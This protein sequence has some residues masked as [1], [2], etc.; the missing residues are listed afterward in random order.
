QLREQ[1]T[2]PQDI[3]SLLLIVGGDVVGRAL[4]QLSGGPITPVTFSFGWVG[5]GISSL[6][7]AAAGDNRLMPSSTDCSCL[8][9]NAKTGYARSNASWVLGRMMRDYEYWMHRQT[10]TVLDHVKEE[11]L[12]KE[13]APEASPVAATT[14]SQ[15]PVPKPRARVG[16]CVAVYEASPSQK[17]GKPKHDLI[18]Y[19]GFATAL[20]QLGI[21]AIPLRTDQDW[22][23]LL[24][25]VSGILLALAT[26]GLPQWKKEKW[27]CRKRSKKDI[28]LT[29][30]NGSQHVI[31]IRGNGI[32]LDLEDL[33]A[34]Q[35]QGNIDATMDG[36][37]RGVLVL[38]AVLWTLLLITATGENGNPWF[39]LGIGTVGLLQN[40]IVA[41]FRRR[42]EA[43]GIH[44]DFVEVIAE[45]KVMNALYELEERYEHAGVALRPIFFPGNLREYEMARW[46]EI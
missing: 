6:L 40:V 7:M 42:P 24:I 43:I 32:G 37:T 44:L 36:K 2:R 39:L 13:K 5:Y 46:A 21:A 26:G 38:L 4:A 19:S 28:M 14:D 10:T 18:F 34:A 8:I 25:T 33:A 16:L 35:L 23:I 31:L 45:A 17:A 15:Q 12:R 20:L 22:N 11:A 3:F 27:A 1:W 29:R 41:G 30:G 9:I